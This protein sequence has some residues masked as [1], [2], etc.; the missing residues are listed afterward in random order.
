LPAKKISPA[1]S[2]LLKNLFLPENN[3]DGGYDSHAQNQPEE[4]RRPAE[5]AVS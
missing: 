3:G 2:K 5:V 4:E 1:F